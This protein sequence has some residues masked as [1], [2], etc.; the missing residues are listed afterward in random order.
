MPPMRNANSYF[1]PA[2]KQ[3][4]EMIKIISWRARSLIPCGLPLSEGGRG[5]RLMQFRCLISVKVCSFLFLSQR[6]TQL[7]IPSMSLAW[8][9]RHLASSPPS[10]CANDADGKEIPKVKLTPGWQG[11]LIDSDYAWGIILFTV[12]L[13]DS[14]VTCTLKTKGLLWNTVG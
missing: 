13:N 9:R 5:G 1:M 6:F 10:C 14:L 4:A 12:T 8:P 2:H 3:Y 7:H 11:V